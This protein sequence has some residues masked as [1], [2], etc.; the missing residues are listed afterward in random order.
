MPSKKRGFRS[1]SIRTTFPHV[2]SEKSSSREV[3]VLDELPRLGQHLAHVGHVP[4]A[5]VG[6][7]HRVQ[8]DTVGEQRAVER[9]RV[10]RVVGLASEA[11][12]AGEDV[13]DVVGPVIPDSAKSSM[14]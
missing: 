14:P 4:V 11:E 3:T 9:E 12:L 10:Q 7:E 1:V 2:K 5:D 13:D 8:P 6:G